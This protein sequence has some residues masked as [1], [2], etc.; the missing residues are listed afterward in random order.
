MSNKYRTNFYNL[1]VAISF[2]A[3]SFLTACSDEPEPVK[4][5]ELGFFIVNEGGFNKQNASLSF[6]DRQKDEVVNYVYKTKNNEGLGDQAQSM[7]VF[8]NKGYIVVQNDHKV[9][10]I[11][12]NDFS[13]IAT[14]KDLPSPRYFQGISSTKGYISDWGADGMTGT[15]K[16]VD[17]TTYAVT[18]TIPVGKGTNKMLKV[19]DL[20][21]VV[22]NGGYGHDNT[23][24]VID[25]K[26]D[27][28]TTTA[29][30]V[31]DNPNSLV[32]DSDGNIWVAAS[33]STVY[34]DDWSI[35]EESS[36]KG[37]LSKIT[38]DSEVLRLTVDAFT[39]SNIKNL[40]ISTDGKTLY[41]T[42][43]D[44]VYSMS[45][46]ATALP[47]T[48]FKSKGYYSIAVDPF[49]GNVIGCEVPDFTSAGSIDIL[50]ASGNTLNTYTTGIAPNGCA[51]K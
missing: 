30:V 29:I 27:A 14:I 18:K 46:S 39:F 40:V 50:D 51:F 19:E 47:T 38:N 5:G 41:Y 26:T 7:A 11:N 42:Y 1:L 10:V 37:S 32:R 12:A 16:V 36:T 43:N 28:L 45:T 25:T 8:E 24:K 21:Y 34:N 17:L 31:G 20:V 3:V 9:E 15:I 48:P 4:T 35:N 49:T 33:G 6:Y 23:V 2:L 22:N 13:A 44:A